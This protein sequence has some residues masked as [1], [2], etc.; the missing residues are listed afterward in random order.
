MN[1]SKKS[2][3]AGSFALIVS[4]CGGGGGG[5][6]DEGTSL[7]GTGS[8]SECINPV[9]FQDGTRF[10]AVREI[11]ANGV[12]VTS[13]T[14][15]DVTTNVEL[16]GVVYTRWAQNISSENSLNS[17]VDESRVT[18]F[19]LVDLGNNVI[20]E[21]V[22]IRSD[23]GT[24]ITEVYTPPTRARFDLEPG[25]EFF[26]SFRIDRTIED[27]TG[28]ISEVEQAASTDQFIGIES[29][30]LPVGT[31]DTC[32][33]E[34]VNTIGDEETNDVVWFHTESGVVAQA[35]SDEVDFDLRLTSAE[36][37]GAALF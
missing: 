29:L 21:G 14:V 2:V 34:S 25:E 19:F 36:L 26:H 30:N 16:N 32:R 1:I 20:D 10:T 8:L 5:G 17:V 7:A 12:T 11:E 3:V 35:S 15:T 9:L 23:S 33:V 27:G 28:S 13:T 24:E 37:N 18:H 6:G 31:V 22:R 4:A